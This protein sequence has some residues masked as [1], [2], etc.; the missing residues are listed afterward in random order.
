MIQS[1]KQGQVES[2]GDFQNSSLKILSGQQARVDPKIYVTPILSSSFANVF[3]SDIRNLIWN[4]IL[5]S[6]TILLQTSSTLLNIFFK[7]VPNVEKL[8]AF[9]LFLFYFFNFLILNILK[10]S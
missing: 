10:E 5:E 8:K 1:S 7:P 4:K 9:H 2:L 3:K 6:Y